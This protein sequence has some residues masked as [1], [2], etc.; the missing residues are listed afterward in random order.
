MSQTIGLYTDSQQEL[1]RA[2]HNVHAGNDEVT[3]FQTIAN[4][5]CAANTKD[6]TKNREKTKSN[7]AITFYANDTLRTKEQDEQALGSY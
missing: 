2:L 6:F 5:L 3:R 7:E 1:A 4:N